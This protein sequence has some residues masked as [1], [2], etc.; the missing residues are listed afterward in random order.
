MAENQFSLGLRIGI[1][2]MTAIRQAQHD[3]RVCKHMVSDHYVQAAFAGDGIDYAESLI[4]NDDDASEFLII[5]DKELI[6]ADYS[7]L[8]CRWDNIPSKHGETISLIVKVKAASIQ[9][10]TEKYKEIIS[11]ITA[12]YGDE[13]QSRPLYE[14]AMKTTLDSSKLKY[15]HLARTGEMSIAGKLWYWL[16]MRI[17]VF[18]GKF[19]MKY[20]LKTG[21]IDW[22]KYRTDAVQNADYRKFDGVLREILSG[23]AIQR[24]E[25]ETYLHDLHKNGDCFYGIHVSSS[26]LVTC[27]INNRVGDHFHFVDGND[28]GYAMAAANMKEQIKFSVETTQ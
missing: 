23:T 27:L 11:K 5:S 20:N 14:S 9:E 26:A 12:V 3:L 16:F 6:D 13:T 1:V 25:L 22:S 2:P 19:V 24:K 28:G 18:I 15:E 17:Q 21:G 8:E 4:K 7:G 10:E